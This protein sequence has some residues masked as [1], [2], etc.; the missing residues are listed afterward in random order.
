MSG[1]VVE[2]AEELDVLKPQRMDERSEEVHRDA[3]KMPHYEEQHCEHYSYV[4]HVGD[5]LREQVDDHAYRGGAEAE[6]EKAAVA[7]HVSEIAGD[8]I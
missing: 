6:R 5:E 1:G 4:R 8:V 2:L 7:Q 3:E